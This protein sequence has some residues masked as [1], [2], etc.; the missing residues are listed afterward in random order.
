[1]NHW[2]KHSR[3]DNPKRK[4]KSRAKRWN[5]RIGPEYWNFQ[6]YEGA[7]R[8]ISRFD[9]IRSSKKLKKKHKRCKYRTVNEL[10]F[11]VKHKI[12]P[13]K[14]FSMKHIKRQIRISGQATLFHNYF[15]RK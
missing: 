12:F 9:G 1:M 14:T 13:N 7:S 2:C 8:Y 10:A 15:H 4:S 6:R 3:F 5:K 11:H